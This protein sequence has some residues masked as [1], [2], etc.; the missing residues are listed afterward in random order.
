ML[1]TVTLVSP[2]MFGRLGHLDECTGHESHPMIYCSPPMQFVVQ[3]ASEV[4]CRAKAST[5]DGKRSLQ[6]ISGLNYVSLMTE[7]QNISSAKSL[8]F[9]FFF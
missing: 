1:N 6:K 9:L 8:A 7:T 5:K 3:E 2:E 4:T